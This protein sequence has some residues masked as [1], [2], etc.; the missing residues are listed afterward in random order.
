MSAMMIDVAE[1][2]QDKCD[3][4]PL[5]SKTGKPPAHAGIP[6]SVLDDPV[7]RVILVDGQAER[8]TLPGLLAALAGDRVASLPGVRV[9]QAHT[10]HMFLAHLVSIAGP[11]NGTEEGAWRAALLSVCDD[12]KAWQ[13]IPADGEYGF[14]QPARPADVELKK[15]EYSVSGIDY[16]PFLGKAHSIK[17]EL[18]SDAEDDVW[19]WQLISLQTAA[20]FTGR[21]NYGCFRMNGGLSSRSLWAV[22]DRAWGMGRRIFEDAT[23]I[24]RSMPKANED[25]GFSTEGL[26]LMWLAPWPEQ[27]R[28]SAS[29]LDYRVIE[30]CRRVNLSR[31]GNGNIFARTGNSEKPRTWLAEKNAGKLF[32]RGYCGDVWSPVDVKKPEAP[33]MVSM[34]NDGLLYDVVAMNVFPGNA[35][36]IRPAPAV[37][38]KVDD[39]LLVIAGIANGQGKTGGFHMRE[40]PLPA[41]KESITVFIGGEPSVTASAMVKEA[42]E[43]IRI[44]ARSVQKFV[45]RTDKR[46][47]EDRYRNRMSAAIDDV[48]FEHFLRLLRKEPEAQFAWVWFLFHSGQALVKEIIEEL[49]M[50]EAHRLRTANEAYACFYGGFWSEKSGNIAF[51]IYKDSIMRDLENVDA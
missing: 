23:L 29:Q 20:G 11:D 44:I 30:I 9:H 8:L 28:L 3:D 33:K 45:G 10:V 39:P 48:F 19:L 25:F 7:F 50:R 51:H 38:R 42:A 4:S 47:Y 13:I 24:L 2:R 17:P 35:S 31:D 34:Q 32:L 49:P 40:I 12:P 27:H 37:Q 6:G 18:S 1:A 5:D 36:T 43:V 15:C 26:K 41:G 21:N 46:P 16:L 22:Y 14:M